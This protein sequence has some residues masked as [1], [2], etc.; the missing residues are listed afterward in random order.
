MTQR[1]KI[2]VVTGA[3]SGMGKEFVKQIAEN[4]RCLDEIWVISRN[5]KRM[6]E[7]R[8]GYWA[9]AGKRIVPLKLDLRKKSEIGRLRERLLAKNPAVKI[10]VCAAGTGQIGYVE[11]L[12]LS[13]QRSGTRLNCEALLSVTYLCLPYMKEKSRIVLMASAAAFVPQHGFAVYAA[14]KAYVLSFARALGSELKSRGITVTAVCP[15]SVDTPFFDKA[16][17]YHKMADFK[18]LFMARPKPVVERA[19]RDAAVGR[20]LSIYGTSMKLFYAACR[21]LPHGALLAGT[22]FLERLADEE[23]R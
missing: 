15:G 11:E 7:L 13:G 3:S 2:A 20:A 1:L 22:R 8:N 9:D 5:K 17:K 21:L 12:P 14:T 23:E 4:Y 10:L 6:E 18:K 16:E 19:L